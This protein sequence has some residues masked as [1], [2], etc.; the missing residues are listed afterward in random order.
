MKKKAYKIPTLKS[1]DIA[2]SELIATS[3][4]IGDINTGPNEPTKSGLYEYVSGYDNGW[5]TGTPD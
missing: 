1:I 5:E 2:D 3:N 4:P